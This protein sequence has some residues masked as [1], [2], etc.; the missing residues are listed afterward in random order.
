MR[1]EFYERLVKERLTGAPV[2]A[3]LGARQV[4][5]S[6]LARDVASMT[7]TH[8]TVF[9]LEDPVAVDRLANPMLALSNL[10]GL[11]VLDEIQRRPDLFPILR[12]LADRPGRKA[13]FLILGSA[14]QDLIR[15]SSESLTGR[16]SF[17][18]LPPF[19]IQDV[20]P[21]DQL[22]IR[23]GYPRSFLASSEQQS[24][25]WREDYLRTTVERDL[26]QLGLQLPSLQTRRFWTMLAHNHGGVFNASSI[27]NSL[28]ISHP[29]VRR[30]LDYMAGALLVRE[31]K[32]WHV[33]VAKRQVKS[34]KIYLRDSGLLHRLLALDTEEAVLSSP[35]AGAS[36]EGYALEQTIQA[37]QAKDDE[38]AFWA[39][40]NQAE[41]DLYL[42]FRRKKVGFEFKRSDSVKLTRS[43]HQALEIL[44][45]DRLYVVYPGMERYPLSEKIEAM[46][47]DQLRTCAADSQN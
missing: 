5:K 21:S 1:R 26:P 2:V 12:V 44:S 11:V 38:I 42:P 24:I 31:L 40:H 29:T 23:G 13:H 32:P 25:Q 27:G 22:W 30:Y 47:I 9:D 20:Q 28:D 7:S 19:G 43:M 3:L 14:S 39:I 15:Q 10:E 4:G 37:F 17:I 36:W 6:T 35:I 46:P 16:I 18:D 8:T 34:P 41:L 33:N 45:L